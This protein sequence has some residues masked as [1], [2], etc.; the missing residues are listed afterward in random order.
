MG[1]DPLSAD[2][3]LFQA[4]RDILGAGEV[5]EICQKLSAHLAAGLQAD[6]VQVFLVDHDHRQVALEML[7]GQASNPSGATYAGL[8]S[9]PYGQVF[10]TGQPIQLPANENCGMLI[11]APLISRYQAIGIVIAFN[12]RRRRPYSRREADLLMTLASQAAIAIDNTR[13]ARAAQNRRNLAE[14]L[15]LAGRRLSSHY[16]LQE[17]PQ[18]ILEQLHAVL[19]YERGSLMLREDDALR[20]A[21]QYGFPDDERVKALRVTLRAGDVFFQVEAAGQPVIVD[22][23]TLSAGWQQVQWLPLNRSWMGVPLFAQDRVL[24]MISLTR[25]EAAAFSPDDAILAS[26]FAL[27]AA[28]ALENANLYEEIVRF[29][30]HLEQMVHQRTEELHQAYQVLE[31]LD[32][33]K[34]DFINV[35]AHELRTP[36][37]VMKG[38]LGMLG[39]DATLKAAP[40]LIEAL[41]GVEQGTDRLY[42]IINSMLDVARI[43]SQALSLH[44]FQIALGPILKRIQ[45]DFRDKLKERQITLE[46]GSFED[47]PQIQAD[48]TLLLKVFQ[49]V[50]GNAIK[51]TPD[52]GQITIS[53]RQ[54]TDEDLGECVEVLVKDTGIGIDPQYHELIFEKFY[55]TEPVSLHSSGKTKFKGGGP[56][57]GLSIARGIVAAHGGRI[58]V[59]SAC[60][61]EAACPGSCFH[62]LLPVR[63]PEAS[64]DSHQKLS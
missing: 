26:T 42:E 49:N 28:S 11:S 54:V 9:S 43:D 45:S 15:L 23:V 20:I 47:L 27:Q 19:P 40:Y 8:T 16:Q 22:D 44:P 13:L 34:S 24:G 38:Y 50:V 5:L 25:R 58:W 7:D 37:T 10:Q 1:C 18:R 29:N 3:S 53:A 46:L 59:E 60:R 36:L 32:Q 17:V 56:G 64:G 4:V 30:E 6:Q 39:A 21:A 63:L 33:N 12:C 61:D 55:R 51:Y 14:T 62:T 35:A 41:R 2:R 57:L 31:K 52:G 48:T